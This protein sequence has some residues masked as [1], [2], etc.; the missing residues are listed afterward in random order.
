M[1]QRPCWVNIVRFAIMPAPAGMAQT[2]NFSLPTVYSSAGALRSRVTKLE[3][4]APATSYSLLF[5]VDSPATLGPG[6]R[7][8]GIDRG[9]RPRAA[10]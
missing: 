2:S 6:A 10:R 8:S 1:K 9:R 7:V 3:K 4:L 5:S